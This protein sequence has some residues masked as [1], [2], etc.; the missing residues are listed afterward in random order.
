M[1]CDVFSDKTILSHKNYTF[2]KK[3]KSDL[4]YF[5][6]CYNLDRCTLQL[7]KT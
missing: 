5:Y 4:L 3:I 1:K 6:F 2:A 7:K